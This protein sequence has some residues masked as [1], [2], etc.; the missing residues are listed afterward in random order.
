[1]RRK[2]EP[3]LRSEKEKLHPLSVTGLNAKYRF[4]LFGIV[5]NIS[6]RS[7]KIL[8]TVGTLVY[9]F[10]M[11]FSSVYAVSANS[12]KNV[13]AVK[14]S[15][16]EGSPTL[17]FLLDQMNLMD[18][19]MVLFVVDL[20]ILV[21][22]IAFIVCWNS[23]RKVRHRLFRW[24]FNN[25]VHLAFMPWF[26]G[27][28]GFSVWMVVKNSFDDNRALFSMACV[29]I[30]LF[31]C[32]IAFLCAITFM[33]STT[34]VNPTSQLTSWFDGKTCFIPF[35]DAVMAA[36]YFQRTKMDQHVFEL[37]CAIFIIL[38]VTI[39]IILMVN[40]PFVSLFY[41]EL[42][43]TK[44]IIMFMNTIMSVV[45]AYYLRYMKVFAFGVIPFVSVFVWLIWHKIVRTR[46]LM[47]EKILGQLE[48]D[49]ENVTLQELQTSLDAVKTERQ[50][51]FLIQTGL[52][53]GNRAISCDPFIEY[54]LDRFPKSEWLVSY[55]VFNYA[56]LKTMNSDVY[57]FALHLLSL[58]IFG[59][60]CKSLLFQVIYCCMQMSKIES[61]IL[62]RELESYKL[63]FYNFAV[64][65]RLFWLNNQHVETSSFKNQL[66]RVIRMY[67]DLRSR[68]HELSELYPFSPTVM[69]HRTVFESDCNYDYKEASYCFKKAM[70]MV[71]N[72][73]DYVTST[74][75]QGYNM[76][77]HT[78]RKMVGKFEYVDTGEYVFLSMNNE[79]EKAVMQA[80]DYSTKDK[81]LNAMTHSYRIHKRDVHPRFNIL[82]WQ[83]KCMRISIIAEICIFFVIFALN[84]YLASL[85][86]DDVNRYYELKR[87]INATVAFRYTMNKALLQSSAIYNF[88]N[89]SY[90]NITGEKEYNMEEV[91]LY[92]EHI[93]N[94]TFDLYTLKGIY[95]S[96]QRYV[97]IIGSEILENCTVD[98]CDFRHLFGRCFQVLVFSY[99]YQNHTKSILSEKYNSLY[100]YG[101]MLNE[102]FGQIYARLRTEMFTLVTTSRISVTYVFSLVGVIVVFWLASVILFRVIVKESIFVLYSIVKTV[103]PPVAKHISLVYESLTKTSQ[104]QFK[105][106]WNKDPTLVWVLLTLSMGLLLA[107][108]I[109]E[110]CVYLARDPSVEV[111]ESLPAQVYLNYNNEF[112]FAMKSKNAHSLNQSEF[113]RKINMSQLNLYLGDEWLSEYKS[114]NVDFEIWNNISVFYDNVTYEM[115]LWSAIIVAVVSLFLFIF[116]LLYLYRVHGNLRDSRKVFNYIPLVATRTNPTIRN[117]SFG[118]QI[119]GKDVTKFVNALEKEP[120]AFDTFCVIYFGDSGR[121]SMVKGN[122]ADYLGFTPKRLEQVRDFCDT[123]V[124]NKEEVA[125]FFDHE[126][127]TTTTLHVFRG[128]DAKYLFTFTSDN[129]LMIEDISS[130]YSRAELDKVMEAVTNEM[131]LYTDGPPA[132]K[133]DEFPG[134]QNSITVIMS[135]HTSDPSEADF[136]KSCMTVYD[137]RNGMVIL[138]CDESKADEVVQLLIEN[139][140]KPRTRNIVC[141]LG[142]LRV[143]QIDPKGFVMKP[144]CYGDLCARLCILADI[145]PIGHVMIS[146]AAVQKASADLSSA[147]FQDTDFGRFAV[148]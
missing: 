107:F 21:V 9:I 127:T 97:P 129:V 60:S 31:V 124:D 84:I 102:L 79:H 41:N 142:E 72:G 58:D 29:T 114:L 126:D 42:Y 117:L 82:N 140:R 98:T 33:N 139:S 123:Y 105:G 106:E 109:S 27:L 68:I 25:F 7:S 80:T 52:I 116:H 91:A 47:Q 46:L 146:D 143:N 103:Q 44:Y 39:V 135:L 15:L 131:Q 67:Q 122:P 113:T 61:P 12:L 119:T 45:S 71:Q 132:A 65:H 5:Y 38:Q 92:V 10:G 121:V 20:I 120:D 95:D 93:K 147:T 118:E 11:W 48:M 141:D 26:S 111:P 30:P 138:S 56:T 24:L 34:L 6:G 35:C 57:R 144:R 16:F 63:I 136:L 87:V 104:R 37:L 22:L 14:W 62:V 19:A 55:V 36:V 137:R 73:L 49:I 145:A 85:I 28:A 78:T 4:L 99:E 77:M 17:C 148:L 40:L 23:P 94:S 43:A 115:V 76:L 32:Y 54:V 81:T 66:F 8:C 2:P 75:Y 1:M 108:P 112:M 101:P 69:F 3:T 134:I 59:F 86:A 18:S 64:V 51:R 70:Y 50:Y 110:L 128:D 133:P 96:A 83:I 53:F 89:M 100:T 130:T 90:W 13:Y 88:W 74:F 125:K